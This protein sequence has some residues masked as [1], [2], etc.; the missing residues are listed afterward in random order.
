MRWRRDRA[1]PSIKLSS[2]YVHIRV[3]KKPLTSLR[4]HKSRIHLSCLLHMCARNSHVA[5]SRRWRFDLRLGKPGCLAAFERAKIWIAT[6]DYSII[7]QTHLRKCTLHSSVATGV[8]HCAGFTYTRR[9]STRTWLQRSPQIWSNGQAG[10]SWASYW[11]WDGSC[12]L[13]A[14]LSTDG[15]HA[16]RDRTET[17]IS[18]RIKRR[19]R[20]PSIY[21]RTAE[22]YSWESTERIYRANWSSRD[23]SAPRASVMYFY[24]S[25]LA[26][27][28]T[29]MIKTIGNAD[30]R[31]LKRRGASGTTAY[32]D[33]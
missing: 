6:N 29:T 30:T 10:P 15:R 1:E 19:E 32:C 31:A 8:L 9:A 27:D 26:R 21:T 28:T 18:L 33:W 12:T 2:S 11:S 16:E 3:V 14:R 22:N 20:I 25:I 24:M 4:W 5:N 7:L 17:T 13:D 23:E